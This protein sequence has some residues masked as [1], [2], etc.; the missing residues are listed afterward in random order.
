MDDDDDD[1]GG[2]GSWLHHPYTARTAKALKKSSEDQLVELLGIC[3]RSSDAA[4]TAGLARYKQTLVHLN[5]FV[6]R[7]A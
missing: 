1:A 2:H 4:V 5:L 3:E 6:A 7:G